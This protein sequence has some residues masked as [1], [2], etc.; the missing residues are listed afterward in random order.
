MSNNKCAI[1]DLTNCQ[2]K[3][4]L[5]QRIQDSLK[6]SDYYGKNWHAF[7]DCLNFDCVFDRIIIYGT[8]SLPEILKVDIEN[9]YKIMDNYK[10]Q[11]LKSG[12]TFSYEINS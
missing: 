3:T 4:E 11:S 7:W 8:K 6:F 1:L 10:A 12:I 2:T 5:H 9:M